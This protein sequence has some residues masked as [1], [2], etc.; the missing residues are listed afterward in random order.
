VNTARHRGLW[1]AAVC[2]ATVCLATSWILASAASAFEGPATELAQA[3]GQEPKTITFPENEVH[4]KT[5]STDAT[6]L[7]QLLFP[8]GT[9]LTLGANSEVTVDSFVFDPTKASATIAATLNRG[10]FRFIGGR[11]SKTRDGVALTTPFG[12]V[13]VE[14]A[15]V[16]LWLGAENA[17]PHFDMLYGGSMTLKRGSTT[18]ARVHSNGYSI[19]PAPGGTSATVRKTPAEWHSEMQE[20]LSHKRAGAAGTAALQSEPDVRISTA[21]LHKNWA[22]C[23]LDGAP[24]TAI[25]TS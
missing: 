12:I 5:V 16:E 15:G 7:V 24:S 3:T 20:R 25:L 4:G 19:V 11:T 2:L 9:A 17:A 18:L 1:V 8:D 23:G 21:W 10:A 13:G 6:G 22:L 14:S